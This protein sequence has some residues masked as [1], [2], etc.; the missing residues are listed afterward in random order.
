[1]VVAWCWG[2]VAWAQGE[3]KVQ[4]T[5]QNAQA[6]ALEAGTVVL[7]ALPDSNVSAYTLTDASGGYQLRARAGRYLLQA[8]Y[9]GYAPS[10]QALE[11]QR[12]TVLG[13][14]VLEAPSDSLPMIEITAAHLPVQVR[15][16]TLSFNSAAFE[17]R[18]HDDVGVLLEQL[19]GLTIREDGSIW[20]N[21][22]KVTE[23]LVDGETYFGEDAQAVLKNLSAD[24]VKKIDITDTGENS[25]G[26]EVENQKTIDLKLKEKAKNNWTAKLMG[27]YGYLV[28]PMSTTERATTLGNHRYRGDALLTIFNPKFRVATFVR[29][30]NHNG[31]SL[32]TA[33]G[34]LLSSTRPGVSRLTTAGVNYNLL[35]HEKW[36]W[37][38]SYQFQQRQSSVPTERLRESILPEQA[39]TQAQTNQLLGQSMRH[40]IQSR[41]GYNIDPKQSLQFGLRLFYQDN[42]SDERRQ[43]TTSSGAILRNALDQQYERQ[44]VRWTIA[45]NLNFTKKF[46]KKGREL[47]VRARAQWQGAPEES[48]NFSFTDLYN[49]QGTLVARDT[50]SLLQQ[51]TMDQQLYTLDVVY[52]EP[53]SKKDKL[54]IELKGGVEVERTGQTALDVNQTD[55]TLNTDFTASFLREYNDQALQLS[56]QRKTKVYESRLD[57]GIKRRWLGGSNAT[58]TLNLAQTLY[59]PNAK[60]DVLFKFKNGGKMT[61]GHVWSFTELQL[62]QLQPLIDNQ[63]PLLVQVGNTQLLPEQNHLSYWRW[64][65]YN[66]TNFTNVYLI[67]QW[68]TTLNTIVRAQFLD[69]QLRSVLQPINAGPA[70]MA[71]I[72]TGYNGLLQQPKLKFD[73]SAEG[74]WEQRPLAVD[75]STT[76]QTQWRYNGQLMVSNSA[77]KIVDLALVVRVE[78]SVAYYPA[79]LEQP[80]LE[81]LNHSYGG[82]LRLTIAKHW[83]VQTQFTAHA[84]SSS[85]FA[86]TLWVPLWTVQIQRSFLKDGALQVSLSGENLLNEALQIR[87]FQTNGFL[88]EQRSLMLGRY[89][90]LVVRYKWSEQ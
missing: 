3:Y 85:T 60:A 44:A 77:K 75:A 74:G 81:F 36:S 31:T 73:L 22:Q 16:D 83:D 82:R 64:E 5:L 35:K 20:F 8:S 41:W 14:L 27:G 6:E 79:A 63:D 9:V 76:Q 39:F 47:R 56:W 29:G 67:G 88:T 46:K 78:G 4:G 61:L 13:A 69:D 48:T 38:W 71:T 1:M 28:P 51:N 86:E 42:G 19:P 50:L 17:V 62:Q 23:V 53:L 10:S 32:G 26:E 55:T 49:D 84:Y 25:K 37:N 21:G 18:T 52:K 72:Q 66:K 11:V 70:Y 33:I 87:R 68:L 2:S 65:R 59:L 89:V 24:A 34:S 45:P 40:I 12:D 54:Y 15:G 7:L 57:V 58:G 90:M 43:E 30:D 80:N